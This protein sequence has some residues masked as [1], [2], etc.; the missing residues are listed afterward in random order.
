MENLYY[1]LSKDEFSKSKKIL[2]WGF[3]GFFFLAGVYIIIANLVFGKSSLEPT[4]SIA[5]F[6]I[7]LLVAAIALLATIKRKDLFF[8][9]DDEK[10]E[11]RYGLLKAKKHLYMWND[12]KEIAMPDKQRKAKLFLKDG[13]SYVIN[14]TWLEGKKSSIIRK[15]I[16]HAAKDKCL[17]VFRVKTLGSMK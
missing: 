4:L 16:Y 5:P 6:G 8:L 9:V 10:I 1:N 7:S 13:S 11:F 14:F 17:N 15:H 2:L 12:I 3:C